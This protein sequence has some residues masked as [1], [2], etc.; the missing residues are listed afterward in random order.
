MS[1][2]ENERLTEGYYACRSQLSGRSLIIID[3]DSIGFR[4]YFGGQSPDTQR[5]PH[6]PLLEYAG[7]SSGALPAVFFVRTGLLRFVRDVL[8]LRTR[9]GRQG[10]GK[11][12]RHRL[13]AG[14]TNQA[15][16]YTRYRYQLDPRLSCAR[17][18]LSSLLDRSGPNS[19]RWTPKPRYRHA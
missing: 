8:E 11:R 15:T 1:R 2:T 13:L 14:L 6:I 19:E 4:K 10:P 18:G 5:T 9:E 16:A 7:Y 3:L 17:L 12:K